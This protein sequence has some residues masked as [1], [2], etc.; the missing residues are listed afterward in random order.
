MCIEY[1]LN[2]RNESMEKLR[3]ISNVNTI[4]LKQLRKEEPLSYAVYVLQESLNNSGMTLLFINKDKNRVYFRIRNNIN[5]Y[6]S[7]I[8]DYT[9]ENLLCFNVYEV[10][11]LKQ[12]VWNKEI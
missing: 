4:N 3:L 6:L 9:Y 11:S 10:D 12:S 8:I 2:W 7:S 5:S 1:I